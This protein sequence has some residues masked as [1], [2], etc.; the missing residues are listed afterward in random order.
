MS[1]LA[2][3]LT[4]LVRAYQFFVRPL[5]PPA[6]RF[7]PSCSDYAVE[8][9][10]THGAVRGAWLAAWRIFRCNPFVAGG[11]DPV[12]EKAHGPLCCHDHAAH[13]TRLGSR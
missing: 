6:C 13:K 2:R 11:Y 3:L 10:R 5:L 12:P 4:I 1:L 9:L 7:V 8:A